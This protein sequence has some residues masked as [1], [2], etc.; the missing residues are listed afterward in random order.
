MNH[1]EQQLQY[2]LGDSLPAQGGTLEVAPGVRWV[3][4]ALPFALDHINLWL[5]RDE[6]DD[7]DGAGTR[8]QGWTVVD[9]CVS[10][11][12]ARAQWEDIFARQLDGLPILRVVVTH[13]HP[14]HLGLAHWLCARWNAPLWISATDYF[15]A[16]HQVHNRGGQGSEGIAA[17]FEQHGLA[18]PLALAHLR[19]PN[20]Y[21]SRLVPAL[22]PRFQRLQDGQTLHIGG[23]DW[24]CISG[25]G[26]APEHI[27]LYRASPA[28][29]GGPPVLIGGDMLLPR[30]S[31]N[32]SVFDTEPESNP[33][34]QFLDSIDKFAALP[35]DTLT[36]PSHGRPFQ[37]LHTRLQQLHAH[38]R[39]HLGRVMTAARL[40][41]CS[42]ADI[43]PVLFARVLDPHQTRFAMGE[44]IAHLHKL[45]F[46]GFV[47][48]QRG[49][50]G[51]V[52]F[53]PTPLGL[54]QAEFLP[55]R[56]SAELPVSA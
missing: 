4:M 23:Q 22:P 42:A 10:S 38:H 28:S 53:S 48:R 5:L 35:A 34:Q 30:I 15:T 56:P 7:P 51:V 40:Q 50:D 18:D 32:V 39:T 24:R 20:S 29:A 44:A 16:Q 33:L 9:C 6:M 21:F 1:L 46:D 54:A 41:P 55:A 37:G 25:Y 19:A 52:R 3:R 43:L 12:S 8:R 36:L 47:Q 26:H 14:D 13:M 49:A 11:D 31:T 17:F 45:W 27:A 2:P